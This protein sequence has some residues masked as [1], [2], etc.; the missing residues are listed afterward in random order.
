MIIRS[1][2]PGDAAAI[3][4]VVRAA[5]AEA[6]HSSGT[7]PAIVD[8]LR[9]AGALA[10]SLVALDGP[11]IAGH[12]AMS[13]VRLGAAMQWY[14]LG[15][16]AVR[17]DCQGK[18]VG[19]ALIREALDHLRERGAAGCVVLGDPAY[20]GRFGFAHDPAI[21][22]SDTPAP[23]FQVLA[24]Q[25]PRPQGEVRYHPAFAAGS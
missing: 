11:G 7:E 21:T 16:V 9:E 10:V 24:F 18:G 20:Y 25:T 12:V 19:S 8:A 17:P 22:Y 4:G 13:P 5:F 14:G 6:E 3:H 15:P 23:F 2:E 1:E